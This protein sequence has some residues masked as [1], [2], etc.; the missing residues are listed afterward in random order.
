M[1]LRIK[2]LV[3]TLVATLVAVAAPTPAYA[4]SFW[5]CPVQMLCVYDLVAGYDPPHY[6]WSNPAASCIRLGDAWR[7]RISSLW[8][9]LPGGRHLALYPSWNCE[10]NGRLD[11]A[12]GNKISLGGYFI[13][14]GAESI[15]LYY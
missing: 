1:K 12:N 6:N 14:N 8:N 11:V 3:V 10:G 13:D 2:L 5:P 9:R 4:G 15:R 7:D